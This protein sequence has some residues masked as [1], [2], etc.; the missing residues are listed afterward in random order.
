MSYSIGSTPPHIG[1]RSAIEQFGTEERGKTI[2]NLQVVLRV[3]AFLR[4]YP[5]QMSVAF[6]LMLIESGF[7]LLIPYL[8]KL[9]IDNYITRG[10]FTGLNRVAILVGLS[11]IGLFLAS[12]GQRYLIT[13]VGQRT[14][15]NLRQKLFDHIQKLSMSYHDRHIV[16][17]TV[18]RVIN[19]VAEIN[20]LISEGVITLVGDIIVLIGIVTIMFSMDFRLALLTFLVLPLMGLT[21]WWF[22]KG[23]RVAFRETRTRVAALVGDLAEDIAGMRVIQA[24][25]QEDAAQKRFQ[26]INEANRD[27]YVNAVSLSF[28]FLPTIEFLGVL[29][30]AIVL[31]FGGMEVMQGGVTYGVLVAFLSYVSR[32]FQPV[33]ELS[34]LFNTMQSAM[35]GGEQVLKLLDT[36]LE[37]SDSPDA[38]EMPSIQGQIELT[39][40]SF[41][42][43]DNSAWVVQKINLLAKPGQ[44]I[45]LVGA[46]GAGKSTIA[47]LM[48]RFYDVVEGVVRIDGID[49]RSVTQNSLR[50]QIGLVP[51]DPFL[52][53]S[54]IA[55]NI[56]FGS[57]DASDESVFEAARLANLHDFISSLPEGYQTKVYEGGANLSY[58]QRQLISI[59][60]AILANP[61]ILILDEATAN[62]DTLT[63]ALIQGAT[64]NLLKGRTAIIIAHRLSTIQ[65]ADWIYVLEAGE[66]VE[67]GTHPKLLAQKGI[68]AGLYQQQFVERS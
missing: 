22:S 47:R 1:P 4:P 2:F 50:R 49:I 27:A 11:F 60:R 17:V 10:D 40:V 3:L 21:T 28:I 59:A 12:A 26:E 43:Q 48:A 37:V 23:A 54:T 66:V 41:R 61:R 20:E 29:A 8:F 13:W 25:V 42:Y 15:A 9:T 39:D 68:Y 58:G 6:I 56:R 34:R 30:T 52:L 32:F 18:S 36:P 5:V 19:D 24:F 51:Q 14:L 31:W 45:A 16:G 67:Q 57:P 44:T 62:V 53:S 63:E 38:V 65:H 33:Q 35:A 64:V 46:T 7:T 55:E